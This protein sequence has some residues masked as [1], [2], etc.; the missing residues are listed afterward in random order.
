M[1]WL[2]VLILSVITIQL[3][4]AWVTT[5]EV[6]GS[7]PKGWKKVG[8]ICYKYKHRKANIYRALKQCKRI[9]NKRDMEE[10]IKE[11]WSNLMTISKLVEFFRDYSTL[12][13]KIKKKII[14]NAFKYHEKWYE[15]HKL[16]RKLKHFKLVRLIGS[17]ENIQEISQY[18][19]DQNGIS[20]LYGQGKD[21]SGL[22][23]D[24]KSQT[25]KVV[26]SKRKYDYVCTHKR[27]HKPGIACV[28]KTHECNDRGVCLNEKCYCY[29]GYNMNMD[30]SSGPSAIPGGG[31]S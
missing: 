17:H 9:E 12:R 4:E 5:P 31:L 30:C 1:K 3:C 23:Y 15:I 29:N 14:L 18:D 22:I 21:L 20:E 16:P 25:F 10:T 19:F 2:L 11:D 7:C 26:N 8:Y 27:K 6:C 28:G 13:R 24:P